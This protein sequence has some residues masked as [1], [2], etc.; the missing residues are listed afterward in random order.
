MAR[1]VASLGMLGHMPLNAMNHIDLFLLELSANMTDLRAAAN[2]ERCKPVK[3]PAFLHYLK[4]RVH[5]LIFGFSTL[6]IYRGGY[7]AVE[8]VVAAAM[9]ESDWLAHDYQH[10]EAA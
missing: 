1:S 2:A 8:E 9:N 3:N 6:L 7:D 10:P 5:G 4:G